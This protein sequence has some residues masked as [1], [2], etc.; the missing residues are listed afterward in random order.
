MNGMLLDAILHSYLAG[1]EQHLSHRAKRLI[2][3]QKV[4]RNQASRE[5]VAM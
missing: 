5:L 2:L 4:C 1:E 3:F